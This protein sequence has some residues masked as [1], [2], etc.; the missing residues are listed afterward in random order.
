MVLPESVHAVRAVRD[1]HLGRCAER[2]YP[3]V[4]DE[5]RGCFDRRP[6]GAVDHPRTAERDGGRLRQRRL[7]R[8]SGR[9]QHPSQT[10]RRPQ[11]TIAAHLAP[12]YLDPSRA[13]APRR[14]F[15]KP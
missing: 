8:G 12:P 9:R 13:R 5:H 15:N 7:K 2:L 1:R 14:M 11:K 6:A 3:A 4:G 10:D